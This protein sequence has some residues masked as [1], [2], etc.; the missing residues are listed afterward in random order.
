MGE[1]LQTGQF[2][3]G[4]DPAAGAKVSNQPSFVIPSAPGFPARGAVKSHVCGF[5]LKENHMKPLTPII[6]TGN[7]GKPK[8]LQFLF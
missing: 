4:P 3:A 8:D 1:R 7:P 5:S 2:A 6:S